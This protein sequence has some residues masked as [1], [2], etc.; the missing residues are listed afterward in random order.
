VF[1]LGAPTGPDDAIALDP[2]AAV[3]ISWS[4]AAPGPVDAYR[5]TLLELVPDGAGKTVA[6]ATRSATTTAQQITFAPVPARRISSPSP[7]SPGCRTRATV[8]S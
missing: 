2:N 1:G 7:R 6:R 3:P 8:T 5:V 4:L